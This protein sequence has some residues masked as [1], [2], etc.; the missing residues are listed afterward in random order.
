MQ[1]DALNALKKENTFQWLK[2][3]V[4][5]ILFGTTIYRFIDH[6]YGSWLRPGLTFTIGIIFS[7]NA[8]S[9]MIWIR[10]EKKRLQNELSWQEPEVL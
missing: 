4:G 10:K 3:A 5:L 6:D 1:Q 7:A 8:I 2:L 9:K